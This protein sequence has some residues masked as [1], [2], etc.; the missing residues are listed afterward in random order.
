[1]ES[2]C[3][4]TLQ[5]SLNLTFFFFYL[6]CFAFKAIMPSSTI[7]LRAFE[8]H[9]GPKT[10][11]LVTVSLEKSI[12]E[13]YTH[14]CSVLK[15]DAPISQVTFHKTF[16]KR[17]D[18]TPL[19]IV[20][21][22]DSLGLTDNDIF[23]LRQ[24]HRLR[25][26]RK[27]SDGTADHSAK[28]AELPCTS[29]EQRQP[30]VQPGSTTAP[31][32]A[33]ENTEPRQPCAAL[34][35]KASL[36]VSKGVLADALTSGELGEMVNLQRSK[37]CI[38]TDVRRINIYRQQ[39]AQFNHV[40][41][42]FVMKMFQLLAALSRGGLTVPSA[43]PQRGPTR[44][45]VSVRDLH[46]ELLLLFCR[47]ARLPFGEADRLLASG[48]RGMDAVYEALCYYADATT[49]PNPSMKAKV[50]EWLSERLLPLRCAAQMIC[51][52]HEGHEAEYLELALLRLRGQAPTAMTWLCL[53]D[54][55]AQE[56]RCCYYSAIAEFGQA[57]VPTHV[58]AAEIPVLE[59]V[60]LDSC[61]STWGLNNI[62]YKGHL[63]PLLSWM[64]SRLV[65]AVMMGRDDSSVRLDE[66]LHLY[67]ECQAALTWVS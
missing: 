37:V 43:A 66:M 36:N 31:S 6:L 35:R 67:S 9:A 64:W 32:E 2:Y 59:A 11:R 15:L 20:A 25:L 8:L 18:T 10:A 50:C 17:I 46:Q 29:T 45:T 16:N 51:I 63:L 56:R 3:F 13:V 47:R 39:F 14:L 33:W 52:L 41:H 26:E 57:S 27:E 55:A 19:S 22:I 30:N 12:A 23:I 5:L 34:P 42:A 60:D 61:C 28:V 65:A 62:S 38:A 4:C 7:H 44:S 1:M 24:G 58:S 53:K 49:A 54:S 40:S 21:P 48:A